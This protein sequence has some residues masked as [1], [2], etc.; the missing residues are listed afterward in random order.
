M[1]KF[2]ISMILLSAMVFTSSLT[3][4]AQE[5]GEFCWQSTKDSCVL[6]LQTTQNNN[7]F[8]FHGKQSCPDKSSLFAGVEFNNVNSH[9]SG[10]GYTNGNVVEIGLHLISSGFYP[11]SSDMSYAVT[12]ILGNI[13]LSDLSL[14]G[15]SI[16][17]DPTLALLSYNNVSCTP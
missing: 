11:G 13:N 15:T 5:L 17:N 10:S 9:I 4:A 14:A 1:R 8:S 7:F 2:S 3:S 16:S 12:E 6:R